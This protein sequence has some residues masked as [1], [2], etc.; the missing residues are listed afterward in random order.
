MIEWPLDEDAGTPHLRCATG[1]AIDQLI[2]H[3]AFRPHAT[4]IRL[5]DKVEPF[6]AGVAQHL[7]HILRDLDRRGWTNH[8]QITTGGEV[9][10]RDLAELAAMRHLRVTL[11]FRYSGIAD[12]RV[13]PAVVLASLQRVA[14]VRERRT[15]VVLDWRPIVPGRNDSDEQMTRVFS[16]ARHAD[17]IVFTGHQLDSS[18]DPAA[19]DDRVVGAWRESGINTPLLRK[20]SCGVSYSHRAADYNG[21]FGVPTLC[22]ICPAAQRLRCADDYREFTS[23]ELE[24]ALAELGLESE[25]LIEDGRVRTSGLRAESRYSLQ[26]ALRHQVW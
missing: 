23:A 7:L 14:A 4:P 22:D 3:Q 13:E 2:D 6:Q 15:G 8:V 18:G 10:A 12:I 9:T 21:Q 17:A 16:A 5:L 25:Y 20:T 24:G 1:E 19:L 26:H 11:L